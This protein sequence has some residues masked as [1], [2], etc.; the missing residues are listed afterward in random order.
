MERILAEGPSMEF[1]VARERG[2]EM[3]QIS[4]EFITWVAL[5]ITAD[6]FVVRERNHKLKATERFDQLLTTGLT[7]DDIVRWL[8]SGTGGLVNWRTAGTVSE[9]PR[10]EIETEFKRLIGPGEL[11]ERLDA[12]G[13][14]LRATTGAA[15][16]EQTA[17]ASAV[18]MGL[19][20]TEYPP[21]RTMT[22]GRA[23]ELAGRPK[24][25]GPPSQRY[26]DFLEFCDEV[27]ETIKAEGLGNPD[28]LDV[29]GAC[30]IIGSWSPADVAQLIPEDAAE[31]ER[32][33]GNEPT[34]AVPHD[35]SFDFSTPTWWVNQG[36]TYAA[37]RNGGYVWAPQT[38]KGGFPMTHHTAVARIRRGDTVVHYAKGHI[39]AVST[40]LAHGH[41]AAR[42]SELPASAWEV[43]GYRADCQY[44]ELD[45]PIPLASIDATLRQSSGG[46]FT[47]VGTVQQGYL[48]ELPEV[49]G[50]VVADLIASATTRKVATVAA[51]ESVPNAIAISASL[52]EITQAFIG[53]TSDAGLSFGTRHETLIRS[54]V[55]ALATKPFVILTGLSGSGKTRLAQ[56]FGNWIGATKVVAV[57]P[58]WSSPDALLGFENA[59]S[60]AVD[61]RHSWNVPETLRFVLEA[62]DNPR[63]PHLLV[64]DEMNLAHVERYFADVLSGME[65]DEPIV[66]NLVL[67]EDGQYR[68][69]PDSREL[70]P[71]PRNL[72][73]V[74]TV[75]IDE[76]TYMFSP[77]VLDR[78]NTFEF[79]VD[80]SDLVAT[81]KP[82][83][84]TPAAES[85]QA[86]FLGAAQIE[87][88][89]DERLS[90]WLR[91]VH[92]ILTEA[93]REFGH[94]TFQEALRFA[95]LFELSG[96]T[97]R[98]T[99][100]DL[101][102]SQKILPRLHGS[103]RELSVLLDRLGGFCHVGPGKPIPSDFHC[104]E[105]AADENTVLRISYAK[106]HRMAKMLQANHFVS[107]AE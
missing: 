44:Y 77:K 46:P 92:S 30:W 85:I 50:A 60:E 6:D 32:W 5:L 51:P 29:Q 12:F 7:G 61:G 105:R 88:A 20:A 1:A 48:F 23:L 39:R 25:S 28:R 80:T 43:N 47:S 90:Q 78:A 36:A 19:N 97:D 64:L 38:N 9:A 33:R 3:A 62:Y 74:G 16:G 59:L 71:L 65:S 66:P 87:V 31:F 45:Q 52:A 68:W 42:P 15:E 2:G 69:N 49:L 10:D 81:S 54:F 101:Q 70:L 18:L 4:E 58:D 103:R 41:E 96:N 89:A 82:E 104:A 35:S 100:L 106:L 83:K 22:I 73:V 34:S 86:G 91:E 102:I 84:L 53:A 56:A 37:E 8:K 40:A 21:H 27:V 79:R 55:S 107:F 67:D 11:N 75:N 99:A 95:A 13:K 93:D 17:V 24:P 14:W 94:R 26:G 98:H 76:T 63:L 57:R 72:F